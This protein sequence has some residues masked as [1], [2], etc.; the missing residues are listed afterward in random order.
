MLQIPGT[1]CLPTI[2]QSIYNVHALNTLKVLCSA[3]HRL[4]KV[5]LEQHLQIV[6]EFLHMSTEESHLQVLRIL[7]LNPELNQRGLA[8]KLG[9]SLG[10]INYCLKALLGR[11]FIKVQNFQNSR[12]KLAYAYILT[13]A[14]ISVK[15]ELT[16]LFLKRKISE[17]EALDHEIEQL[18]RELKAAQVPTISDQPFPSHG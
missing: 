17:Y 7:Q 4:D 3:L 15:A 5:S 18:E 1:L 12:N 14:G 13:P 11:G 16:A 10:K 8:L 2:R 9:V 6:K